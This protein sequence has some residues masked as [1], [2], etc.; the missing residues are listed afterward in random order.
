VPRRAECTWF[1]SSLLFFKLIDVVDAEKCEFVT[2]SI[3]NIQVLDLKSRD[4]F[5]QRIALPRGF[6]ERQIARLWLAKI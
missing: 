3:E 6:L 1:N 5:L 4:L 2:I